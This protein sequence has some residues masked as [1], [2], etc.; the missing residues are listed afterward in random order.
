MDRICGNRKNTWLVLQCNGVTNSKIIRY[1]KT[2]CVIKRFQ[3]SIIL[4]ICLPFFALAD[5]G[6]WVPSNIPDSI[7]K[8]MQLSGFELSKKDLYN[9][10][11]C[12]LI[13][14]VPMFG[15][16]CSA[17]VVSPDGLIITNFHCARYFIQSH[18]TLTNNLLDKG[19][20]ATKR[21]EEL[22]NINL[23]VEFTRKIID[24]TKLVLEGTKENS[25]LKVRDSITSK[26]ISKIEKRYCDSLH[27][28]VKIEPL[29]FGNTYLLYIREEY[30]D[31]RLV[32]SPPESIA[33]YG[34]DKDNWMWPRHSADFAIF[35]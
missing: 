28:I 32:Y 1:I 29:F 23:T 5:E 13:D 15:K 30:K 24:V 26:N 25:S 34:G 31:I 2:I 3:N 9:P 27:L 4:I 14:A 35:R 8:Q 33:D 16:G 12:S 19:F 21:S 20:T 7:Y 6:M 11:S 17:G 18:S 10:D 22:T